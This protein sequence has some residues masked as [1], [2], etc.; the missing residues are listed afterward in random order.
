MTAGPP[1]SVALRGQRTEAGGGY[2]PPVVD[3][4]AVESRVGEPLIQQSIL[5]ELL[6]RAPALIFVADAEMRYLAVNATA[7]ETLGYSREELLGLRVTDIAVAG[8]AP[9]LYEDMMRRRG[10]TGETAIRTKDGRVL[11]FRYAAHETSI[12]GMTYYMA[13]GLVASG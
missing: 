12:A 13:I 9:E 10:A 8:D 1:A 11:P 5:L 2:G 4:S 7:C 6:D 3:S